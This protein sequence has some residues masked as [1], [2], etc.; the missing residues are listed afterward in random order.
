MSARDF[1]KKTAARRGYRLTKTAISG[2]Q[3]I[4]NI[5]CESQFSNGRMEE[6]N[7]VAVVW[8][9]NRNNIGSGLRTILLESCASIVYQRITNHRCS[10][11]LA[12]QPRCLVL[13]NIQIILLY[14]AS[15]D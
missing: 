8:W 3:D 14:E 12:S 11:I 4:G 9:C 5:N 2:N 6:D 1:D 7:S 13:S 10:F 15:E